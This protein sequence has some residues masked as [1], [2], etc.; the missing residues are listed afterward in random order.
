M[1]DLA[2]RGYRR[3]DTDKRARASVGFGFVPTVAGRLHVDKFGRRAAGSLDLDLHVIARRRPETKARAR[4][5]LFVA[6]QL[7]AKRKA[8]RASILVR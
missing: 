5:L 2:R 3:D 1:R 8:M 4:I 6:D 7:R